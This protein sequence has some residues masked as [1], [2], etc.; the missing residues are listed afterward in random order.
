MGSAAA[1]D[2]LQITNLRG[3]SVDLFGCDDLS[4]SVWRVSQSEFRG[5]GKFRGPWPATKEPDKPMFLRVVVNGDRYCVKAYL[6][7]ANTPV[8]ATSAGGECQPK[9][10]KQSKPAFSRGVGEGCR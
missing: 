7:E 3:N 6:V 1:A 8:P 4:K 9:G 2:E 10:G 5:P